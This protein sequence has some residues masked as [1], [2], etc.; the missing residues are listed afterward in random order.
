M[1]TSSPHPAMS[2]STSS[3]SPAMTPTSFRRLLRPDL[4]TIVKNCEKWETSLNFVEMGRY[5]LIANP[6]EHA[7]SWRFEQMWYNDLRCELDTEAK[8]A[9]HI[10]KM[11]LADDYSGMDPRDSIVAFYHL[12]RLDR[13]ADELAYIVEDLNYYVGKVFSE[14]RFNF[15]AAEKVFVLLA[16]AM[17]VYHIMQIIYKYHLHLK[18]LES[19]PDIK[20][21]KTADKFKAIFELADKNVKHDEEGD[22]KDYAVDYESAVYDAA[23]DLGLLDLIEDMPPAFDCPRSFY[24]WVADNR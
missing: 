1:S 21:A 20:R 15:E 10:V 2:T 24:E 18:P 22:Y 17:E 23:A 3:P 5:L 19:N 16:R 12:G 14:W 13:Y 6:V 9:E 7:T 8:Y 4:L 11:R